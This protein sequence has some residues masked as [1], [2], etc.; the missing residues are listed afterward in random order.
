MFLRK[1]KGTGPDIIILIILIALAVWTGSFLNPSSALNVISEKDP[2]PL[3]RLLEGITDLSPLASVFLA[4]LLVMLIAFL[5]IDFNTSALFLGER[6]FLPALFYV[7]VSGMFTDQQGLNPALPAAV[8]LV[9]AIRKITES[10]KIQGP[11]YAFFDA[12]LL[13]GTGSFFY[14]NLIWFGIVLFTGIMIL[15]SVSLREIILS[16]FGLLTPYFIIYGFIFVSGMDINSSLKVFKDNLFG[17]P[18]DIYYP[19]IVVAIY[20]IAGLIILLSIIH[21]VMVIN[22][23]KIKSR[24]TLALLI[25][26]LILSGMMYLFFDSVSEEIIWL[27]G[28]PA[29]YFLSHFFLFSKRKLATELIFIVIPVLT[30]ILQVIDLI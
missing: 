10:Y 27:A 6:T 17:Q 24:K 28:I 5:L 2:M 20:I 8:F 14:A 13:I 12:G 18:V 30:V 11:A 15:R 9:L 19:A 23:K 3:F 29:S 26:T 25:W 16:L 4:F 21:L 7:M 1:F 22:A